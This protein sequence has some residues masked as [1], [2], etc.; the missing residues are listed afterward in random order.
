MNAYW[1]MVN[2]FGKG[3]AAFVV[4]PETKQRAQSKKLILQIE[5]RKGPQQN[6]LTIK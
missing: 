6:R 2:E 5:M 3:I 1:N 4:L